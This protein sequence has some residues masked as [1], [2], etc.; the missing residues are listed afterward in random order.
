MQQ[1]GAHMDN[2]DYILSQIDRIETAITLG[3]NAMKTASSLR[4]LF[5]RQAMEARKGHSGSPDFSRDAFMVFDANDTVVQVARLKLQLSEFKQSMINIKIENDKLM[6][7]GGYLPLI[8]DSIKEIFLSNTLCRMGAKD[9][10][11]TQ[12]L[13]ESVDKLNVLKKELEAML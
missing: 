12:V 2:K 9:A 4:G 5:G 1:G 11:A 13:G 3:E 10:A 6:L 8:D 7:E